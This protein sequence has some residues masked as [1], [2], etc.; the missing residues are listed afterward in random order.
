M[1]LRILLL[2]LCVM[3]LLVGTA[4]AWYDDNWEYRKSF[5]LNN[6][7]SNL[8]NYQVMFTVNR[9]AGSDTG[10][11]VFLN[12]ECE[13]D[14]D[15]IRFVGADDTTVWDYWFESSSATVATI[16]VEV[17]SIP[18]STAYGS[19][20]GCLYYG[21][22]L[23]T[24]ESSG[25][26][27]FDFFDDFTGTSLN[28]T[29]WTRHGT[30]YGTVS[31]AD[32]EINLSATGGSG[33]NHGIH[34]TT[35]PMTAGYILE[36]RSKNTAG[37]HDVV[38]GCADAPYYFAPHVD[39]STDGFSWYAR[40]GDI[41]TISYRSGA[42]SVYSSEDNL[43]TAY[44]N[45]KI[46]WESASSVKFYKDGILDYTLSSSSYIPSF[47]LPVYFSQDGYVKP[48]TLV[49]DRVL[50]RK[51]TAT[52]PTV[53]TW[54]SEEMLFPNYI[55]VDFSGVPTSGY[56]PLTV[57]YTDASIGYNNT[58]DTWDWSFGDSSANSTQQNP[59]HTY[60][61]S[62]LYNVILTVTNT[63][64]SKTNTTQKT[65]YI[66][67]TVNLDVPTASFTGAPTIGA[68][69]LTVSFTDASTGD[70]PLSYAWD[71]NNDGS[72]EYYTQNPSH[73]YSSVGVYTVKL[74][75]TNAFG[76]SWQNRTNYITTGNGPAASFTGAPRESDT[77]PVTV[78]FTDTSTNSPTAWYW[79]ID[80]DGSVDYTTQNCNHEYAAS[81]LY[82]VNLTVTNAFGTSTIIEPDYIK[83]GVPDANFY[84]DPRWSEHDPLEVN[85]ND[86][87]TNTPTAWHWDFGDGATSTEQNPTHEYTR[88]GTYSVTLRATNIVGD[89]E[90]N[91][92][93]YVSVG[94]LNP[95]TPY[96]MIP[97]TP[98]PT[99][100][101][102]VYATTLIE[103]NYNVTTFGE[104]LPKAFTD[105]IDSD[106]APQIFWGIVFAFVFIA[107]FMRVGDVPLLV[108]FGL[109]AA[110][111]ILAFMPG[112][113]QAIAQAFLVVGLA[114]IFYILIKGRFR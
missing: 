11:T 86:I 66:N 48:S 28:A 69:P 26:S 60:T 63:S 38:I 49:I 64:F 44:K 23:A 20:T 108:L 100:T 80:N 98:R 87:S 114:A 13:S 73:I 111:T 42:N 32:G 51:Y 52:E 79:D 72:F 47:N 97:V 101:F 37:W 83:A 8:T 25:S 65:A 78:S 57:Y 18:N 3:L 62:G 89:G 76:V 35:T 7:G 56:V 74:R 104:V 92:V 77:V 19:T 41:S 40:V 81:G 102:G 14:Y 91:K 95:I 106:I 113:W 17:P 2:A 22:S 84:A 93:A 30:S 4:S 67:A 16:W 5:T 27:V 59:A 112:E 36:A 9:S 96:D 54:G 107:L 75:V 71:V 82:T 58:P 90:E 1:N 105:I 12:G 50:V 88:S 45:Y 109:V 10:F 110:G 34:S 24:S 21:N 6:S 15:D 46:V 53:S 39:A 43:G 31:L 70:A 33:Q 29:K 99:T 85:F 94:E 61:T 68:V 103:S 55:S